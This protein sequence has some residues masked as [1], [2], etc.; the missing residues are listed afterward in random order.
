MHAIIVSDNGLSPGRRQVNQRWG[1]S[2]VICPPAPSPPPPPPPP[3]PAT[4]SRL[5]W[6]DFKSKFIH[7]HPRKCISKCGLHIRRPFLSASMLTGTVL[8]RE[9]K[10]FSF[11]R[12]LI[13]IIWYKLCSPNDVIQI[14][15]PVV[16]LHFFNFV[17]TSLKLKVSVVSIK[18]KFG[19]Y[20]NGYD[21]FIATFKHMD[22]F[23]GIKLILFITYQWTMSH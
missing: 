19:F 5:Q 18:W 21:N 10:R 23:Y 20:F 11:R 8:R 15:D 2:I 16:C 6:W 22:S 1:R 3:P 17:N 13:P 4:R 9:E 12:F 14:F 7:V